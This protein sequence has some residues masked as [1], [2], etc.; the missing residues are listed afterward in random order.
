[1]NV[2]KRHAELLVNVAIVVVMALIG[3]SFAYNYFLAAD[4]EESEVR[5]GTQVPLPGVDWAGSKQT[6]LLVL[7]KGCHFCDESAPFYRRLAGAAAKTDVRLVAVTPQP[8]AVSREYLNNLGVSLQEV[9]QASPGALGLR[10]TPTLILVDHRGIALDSWV[11]KLTPDEE[12]TVLERLGI[13]SEGD[14]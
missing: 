2:V 1:M 12:A 11:G 9:R 14:D 6:L 4:H 8:V 5:A 10:G 7:Q 13:P 3:V